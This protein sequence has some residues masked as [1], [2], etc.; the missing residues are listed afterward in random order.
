MSLPLRSYVGVLRWVHADISGYVS[1]GDLRDRSI[2]LRNLL[3]TELRRSRRYGWIHLSSQLSSIFA[4]PHVNYRGRSLDQS[5]SRALQCQQEE[6][7]R[8]AEY[9]NELSESG[10]R[11]DTRNGIY[12][13]A[14]LPARNLPQD[15]VGSA[16]RI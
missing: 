12:R 3:T 16:N 2:I 1:T 14:G 10:Q 5:P 13:Q 4:T 7:G 15:P 11:F 8:G 9:S 6:S